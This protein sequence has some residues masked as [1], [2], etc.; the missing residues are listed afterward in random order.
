[1]TFTAFFQ[2]KRVAF[3]TLAELIEQLQSSSYPSGQFLI[4][5]DL[6]GKQLDLD[7][8]GTAGEIYQRT[9]AC[10]PELT[11][12]TIDSSIDLGNSIKG[13]GRP[14]LGVVSKE[15]TLLPRHWEWLSQQS[16]GASATLRRLVEKARKENRDEDD[17]RLRHERAY[18]FMSAI[19]GDLPEYESALRALFAGNETELKQCIKSWPEDLRH[20]IK[21]LA[22]SGEDN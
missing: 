18:L 5:N 7:I 13:R 9:I 20:Y 3:G 4:F 14:K 22:F 19:A 21:K 8:R 6:N 11:P 2:N 16:G 1:M 12:L 15:V 17:K 10:Y